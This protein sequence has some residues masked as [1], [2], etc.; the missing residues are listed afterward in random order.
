MKKSA[1]NWIWKWHFVGG[2]IL[3]PVIAILAITGIIYLFKD[4]YES[5]KHLSFKKVEVQNKQKTYQ[6]QWEIAADHWE[7]KINAIVVPTDENAATEFTSGKFGR[8]SSLFVN[9]YTGKVTGEIVTNQ[10]DMYQVRKL[11]GELLMGSFGT[12]IIELIGSWLIVLIVTGLY[13]FLP[14]RW[15]DWNK[16]FRIRFNASKSVIYR[17]VHMVGGFWF[18]AILLIILAGGLPWTDVWGAGFKWV[19]KQT[20]TGYPPSWQGKGLTSNAMGSTPVALDHIVDKVLESELPGEITISLPQSEAGLFSVHNINFADQSSQKAIHYDQYSG[21]EIASQNWSDVG[22][23]MRARM[24]AMAFHQG[25]FGWWNWL[26]V[27]FTAF[28]LLFLSVS[29]IVAY[30]LKKQ[31]GEW[32]VP[33]PKSYN[34]GLPFYAA[35]VVLG[36]FLPLFGLSAVIIYAIQLVHKWKSSLR[37]NNHMVVD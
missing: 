17:D 31:T 16:L 20:N 1:Y 21:E 13:L 15:K 33:S 3:F 22:W 30:F 28:G 7:R 10:T 6:Q 35:V 9:P 25:Q 24:W 8:K 14:R 5:S 4:N 26:L 36:L 32:G 23:L 18:S 37:S 27:L 12:K 29:A 2:L 11:H 34:V 19:Q